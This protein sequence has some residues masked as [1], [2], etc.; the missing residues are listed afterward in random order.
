MSNIAPAQIFHIVA[1]VYGIS[2]EDICIKTCGN[3]ATPPQHMEARG[4][5]LLLCYR[6]TM[7]T[8][9][10]LC[11]VLGLQTN[12]QARTGLI[13]QAAA[14]AAAAEEYPGK[15]ELMEQAELIIDEHHEAAEPPHPPKP[16]RAPPKPPA[17]RIKRPQPID[18]GETT[19]EWWA[20]NDAWFR[21]G[22]TTATE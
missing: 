2:F 7:A 13:R 15:A 9:S 14:F 16:R 10:D 21:R 11:R 1:G 6:H 22:Y 5:A 4:L 18:V 19:L 3:Y 17:P 8:G 12:G 20:A